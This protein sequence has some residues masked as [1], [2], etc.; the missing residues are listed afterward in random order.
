MKLSRDPGS[1]RAALA[2]VAAALAFLYTAPPVRAETVGPVTDEIGVVRIPKGQPILVGGMLVQSGPDLSLGTDEMRGAQIAFGDAKDSVVGHPLRFT[3]EDSGC[4]AEGGQTAAARIAANR[5]VVAVIGPSCS[6]EG[7]A[8]GPI[9]WNAGI[10][11]VDVGGTAPSLT[12]PDRPAGLHG[13]VR[14]VYNDLA[15]AKVAVDYAINGLKLKKV[16]T[17]HDGSTYA[18]QVVRAFE[19]GFTA[20]GG[21]IVAREAIS[22]SDTDLR[23]VLTRIGT[24]APEMLFMPLYVGASAYAVRQ[25]K[26][27]PSLAK[28]VLLAS[29]SVLAPAFLEAAGDAAVGFRLISV[30]NSPEALG[31]RYVEFRR[32][33]KDRFGEDPISGFHAYGHDGAAMLLAAIQKVAVKDAE[34]VTYIGRKA[35]RDALA[36]TAGFDGLTGKLTCDRYGDC[37]TAHFAIMEYAGG[38][39][40][41]FKE[42]TNPKRVW[43]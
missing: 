37:G 14:V 31:T 28:T 7:R 42:G 2:T 30:D 18:E 1:R 6:S 40:A 21:T 12:A 3:A 34:G 8:G 4:S 35:L 41:T 5:Q 26:E 27:V 9:L 15:A 33:Y 38:D 24:S 36:S 23:P 13:L 43:P 22:G 19:Q 39:P 25:A 11:Q 16:A 17:L 29:D 10:P 32:K 20:A